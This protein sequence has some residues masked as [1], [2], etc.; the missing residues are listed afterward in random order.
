MK[1]KS[2]TLQFILI[3]LFISIPTITYAAFDEQ[4][5]ISTKAI[6]LANAVTA[7]PPG[8]MS[9]HYNPA[10]LSLIKP[11]KWFSQGIT[12][13]FIKKTSKFDRDPN[14]PGIFGGFK[15][16]PLLD[17]NGH[18]E[19]TNTSGKMF[20]PIINQTLNFLISPTLGIA[21]K[22][23]GSKW[24]F[25]I[26]NYAPFAV[27]LVHGNKNDPSRFGGWEV[28]QQHLIYAAPAVSYQLTDH[29]AVGLAVGMGQTA[30][31]A[32]V[33]MRNPNELV[34]LTKIL[35]NATK[36]L[37][38]PVI[39]E[40]TLPPPWFGGGVGPFDK[41]ASLK[42][43]LRDDFS[44]NYNLGIL[45]SPFKWLSLG[46]CYQS[47]IKVQ[48]RGKYIIKYSREWQRMM[49][50]FGSSPLLLDISGMFDL[51]THGVPYQIGRLT[52]KFEF[53]QRVQA[54][55]KLTLF[56]KIN[57][58]F[59][60]KW[61]NWSVIKQDNFRF[62]RP[63]QLL[64]VAKMS[65][66]VGGDYNLI[67]KRNFRDTLDWA[68][69]IEYLL[70][71]RIT[72]RA[73]Y[74]WRRTPVRR[75]L[76]DLLYALPDLHYFGA[77]VSIK[78][79][80]QITLDLGAAYLVKKGFKIP[81]NSSRNLNSNVFTDI[82]YNPYAGLNYEQDTETYMVSTTMT[83]PFSTLKDMMHHQSEMVK[84]LISYLTFSRHKEKKQEEIYIEKINNMSNSTVKK[85]KGPKLPLTK[86]KE[87]I[88][89]LPDDFINPEKVIKNEI[90]KW[91]ASW[92]KADIEKFISFYAPYSIR[93]TLLGKKE[94]Y[95]CY[96]KLW[97]T[98][99]PKK[100]SIKNLKIEKT[101]RGYLVKFL[102]KF[103]SVKGYQDIG[104]TTLL[105]EKTNGKYKIINQQWKQLAR[106]KI[107]NLR[108]QAEK[109]TP[110]RLIKNTIYSWLD[111][112]NAHDLD[113]L[114]NYYTPYTI[115]GK[116]LGKKS[117]FNYYK[118]LFKNNLK[119]KIFISNISINKAKRGYVVRFIETYSSHLKYNTGITTL[120][121]EKTN[122]GYKIINQQ[123]N[124]IKNKE[125][126]NLNKEFINWIK[127][128]ETKN[129]KDIKS[130]YAPYS[131]KDKDIG[132]GSITK[133]YK[134]LF[135]NNNYIRN[136]KI[137][138]I[139]VE[140]NKRGFSM[141]YILSYNTPQKNITKKLY[142]LWEKIGNRWKII[143][144]KDY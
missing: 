26:G 65:G 84:K 92:E 85:E 88:V 67:L 42:V 68:A 56:N 20:I 95:N 17:K 47:P 43:R 54:G 29:L 53:P 139:E 101:Q 94:I 69:G 119:T 98:N 55:I 144:E 73:G 78:L 64:R 22:K 120:L 70:N 15:N 24:T 108:I 116:T 76:Y 49:D 115:W 5:A 105:L 38:I 80:K 9:I 10:G 35:G 33:D 30:L 14:W 39:S 19:G 32:Q 57:L 114:I 21:Y 129:W 50:W 63:I 27:G 102:Q 60:V 7:N 2:R 86:E 13:P 109:N 82:V 44:P 103:E 121:L 113:K 130:F 97:K 90:K 74:E 25:A 61:A 106:S 16:D 142:M 6:S 99:K 48:L 11:G 83:M 4:L 1:Y 77:G 62:D 28:Y 41:L 125:I 140:K 89:K 110:I 79:P 136:F 138:D 126:K 141:W 18:A 107:K 75:Y 91:I 31:G 8:I 93:G 137:R 132:I 112:Y 71:K 96:K 46:L 72:L 81:D 111:A 118:N 45:W 131:I 59:D 87:L 122:G 100:I 3:V 123:W 143:G 34:A 51:P 23:P 104:I 127:A 66:Y 133:Y 58:M 124:P 12:I 40:L 37:E 128:Y 36:D 117:I 134:Q 135:S 52:S